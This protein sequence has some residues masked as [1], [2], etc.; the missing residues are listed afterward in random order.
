MEHGFD[1][2][3]PQELKAT[4]RP[5]HRVLVGFGHR[6]AR[7]GLVWRVHAADVNTSFERLKPV[8]K[9]L[10]AVP[11][12]SLPDMQLARWM[13]QEYMCSLGE[14]AFSLIPVGG[15]KPPAR[16]APPAV[17]STPAPL[18]PA[19]DFHLT[20]GQQSALD[21]ILPALDRTDFESFLLFGVAAAGKTEVYLRAIARVLE[22]KGAAIFLVPEIGLTPQMREQLGARF[23]PAVEVWHS[24]TSQGERWRVWQRALSGQCRVVLGPRSALF[25]PMQKLRLIVVDE[26]H[27]PSYKEDSKPRYNARDVALEKARLHKAVVL[28]GSATPSMETYH[29]AANGQITLLDM[30]GRVDDRPF[31]RVEIIDM[32]K[33]RGAFLA[34]PLGQA[35]KAALARREQVILFLNRRGFSTYVACRSCGW[36]AR[37]PN[38]GVSLVYHKA[39]MSSEETALK[40]GLHCHYCAHYMALPAQCPDC[41]DPSVNLKGKGTQRVSEDLAP[42]FPGARVL[43]WDRDSTRKRGAHSR[44]FHAVRSEEVDILVGTQMIAQGL[45][46][47]RVTVVGVVD[48]DQSL[49]FP[50]F[51]SGERT[52]QLLT[53]VAGRAGRADRPGEVFLQTRHPEHYAVQ[54]AFSFDFKKFAEQEL[55]FRQE[56]RYPPYVRLV[57]LIL[58]GKNAESVEKGADELMTWLE[59]RHFPEGTECLGPAPAFHLLRAGQTHWQAL[60]KTPPQAMPEVLKVLRAY[61]PARSLFLAVDVDPQELH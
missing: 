41:G 21:K 44:A 20:P 57:Q 13:A 2:S 28:F 15:R 31:P 60:L 37:C 8:E 14:A 51:R 26:E 7:V 5:G 10:D 18:S 43:Q 24:E 32:K 16:G 17:S 11:A 9:I 52:F 58:R 61:K 49:R 30:P 39:K 59:T 1:Y 25:L 4:L 50:D 36:E 46:F 23:G 53:Q 42:I 38:C 48:A 55:H 40:E 34:E 22:N 33:W 35:V 27:D 3:V 19:P 56:M 54:A 29:R 45:D 12:L 47:P 6:G